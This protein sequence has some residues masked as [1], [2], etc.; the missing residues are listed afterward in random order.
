MQL[1]GLLL[2][3]SGVAACGATDDSEAES[4]PAS[5]AME[6]PAASLLPDNELSKTACDESSTLRTTLYGALSGNV[7]WRHADMQCEGMPRPGGAGARLRFAGR[8]GDNAI[9]IAFIIAMPDLERGIDAA[10]IASNVTVIEESSAR[11]FSTPDLESCWTDVEWNAAPDEDG[12]RF[13]I[14]GVLYCI[15]PLPEVNG[16]A[17]IS[18][19]EMRFSGPLDWSAT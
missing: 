7:E 15:S 9:P 17:S 10:E 19:P 6:N 1:A 14:G 4:A 11:F 8:V 18:I 13:V 12:D 5:T 3:A 16:D 2:A